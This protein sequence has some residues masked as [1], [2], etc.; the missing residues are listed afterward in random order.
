MA[1]CE[2][3]PKGTAEGDVGTGIELIADT[4]FA[5][6]EEALIDARRIRANRI[7]GFEDDVKEF[8]DGEVEDLDEKATNPGDPGD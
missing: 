2:Q 5:G 1:S 3:R 7:D 8:G 6:G 4:E